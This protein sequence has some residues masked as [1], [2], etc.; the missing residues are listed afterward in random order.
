[1]LAVT[2]A[3]DLNSSTVT[4]GA[5]CARTGAAARQS[6]RTNRDDSRSRSLERPTSEYAKSV[7]A[8]AHVAGFQ[9]AAIENLRPD[10]AL[11]RS[12]VRAERLRVYDLI[13]VATIRTRTKA[14]TAARTR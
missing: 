1:M 8:Q 3:I 7:I 4:T 14:S 11:G 12:R 9:L 2:S 5:V 13:A 6:A 10:R